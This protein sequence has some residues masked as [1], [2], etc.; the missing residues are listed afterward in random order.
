MKKFPVVLLILSLLVVALTACSGSDEKSAPTSTASPTASPAA[1]DDSSN[2][3]SENDKDKSADIAAGKA[4]F[5]ETVLEGNAGCITCHS[6]EPGK[7]VVGPSLAGIASKGKDFIRE[8]IV[9]PDADITE[10]FTAG[11]MPANYGEKLTEEQI[12][13]LVEYMMT[14]K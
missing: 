1:N 9:N 12:N 10:G 6:L 11:I 4:L 14:L 5:E 3:S 2:S 13:R 8:S 7:T